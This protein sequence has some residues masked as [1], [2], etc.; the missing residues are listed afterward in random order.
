MKY[1][2]KRLLL[3]WNPARMMLAWMKN[4]RFARHEDVSLYRIVK[5]FLH[6]LQDD[7]I[8]DRTNGVA[9][10]FIMAIFPAIIFLFTLI[11]YITPYFPEINHESIMKF[12]RH[13]SERWLMPKY[14]IVVASTT[15]LDLVRHQR[16]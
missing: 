11:P 3:Q 16:G 15:I 1:K 8:M 2:H 4:I 7:E 5:R 10:N 12:M 6:N 14:M 13:L 9:F